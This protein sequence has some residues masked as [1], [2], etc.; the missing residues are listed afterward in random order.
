MTDKQTPD[1]F[2]SPGEE[3]RWQSFNRGSEPIG[4][5]SLDYVEKVF[6]NPYGDPALTV[7]C[8]LVLTWVS[9]L[10][11]W[12]FMDH[13]NHEVKVF[14]GEREI[15]SPDGPNLPV[16]E[17]KI[18]DPCADMP[19]IP[20][21]GDSVRFQLPGWGLRGERNDII[22]AS[23]TSRTVLQEPDCSDCIIIYLSFNHMC[24]VWIDGNKWEVDSCADE[25][26]MYSQHRVTVQI[27]K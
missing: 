14:L 24:L 21:E 23:V 9:H 13:Y 16:L 7:S 27:V 18:P 17:D 5:G 26:Y 12:R 3:I 2:P 10:G 4:R 22:S 25:M 1:W 20:K 11:E 6:I 8:E 15:K 19:Q